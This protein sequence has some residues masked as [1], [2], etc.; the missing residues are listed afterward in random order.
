MKRRADLRGLARAAREL[1]GRL[2]ESERV[3][4]G[5]RLAVELIEGCDHAG[6]TVVRDG[7][8]F[9]GAATDE[10]VVR[11]DALQYETGQGPCLQAVRD[12]KTVLSQ[13]LTS[14]TRWPA[15]SPRAAAEL[16]TRSMLSVLIYDQHDAYGALNLY[17]DRVDGFD[18]DD[19][20]LALA[21]ATQIALSLASGREIDQRGEA[22]VSR[23]TIGQAQGILMER[24]GISAE[25]AFEYL[26]RTSQQM[27]C[28][29]AL[30]AQE[31]VRTRRLP[32][33]R[34]D[35]GRDPGPARG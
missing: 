8:V 4:A 27:N 7:R 13:D 3:R 34:P 22:M 25:Q 30:I 28:K 6:V 29:L 15:W 12:Q 1:H 17:G 9:T 10:V 32:A 21:L 26:R 20:E 23:T 14:E 2:D 31:L 5:V 35:P 18:G 19:I 33:E 11:G 16:G 24:L